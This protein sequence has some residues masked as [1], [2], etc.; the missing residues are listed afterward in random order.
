V[1]GILDLDKIWF[2]DLHRILKYNFSIV[3]GV[4]KRSSLIIICCR[5]LVHITGTITQHKCTRNG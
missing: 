1:I 2:S 3:F 5:L 4:E